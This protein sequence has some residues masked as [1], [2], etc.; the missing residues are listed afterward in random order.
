MVNINAS[1]EKTLIDPR[2]DLPEGLDSFVFY[3]QPDS[4]NSDAESI[5]EPD[6]AVVDASVTTSEIIITDAPIVS[7][8]APAPPSSIV[9]ISQ[10]VRSSPDGRQVIDVVIE[11]DDIPGVINYDVRVTAA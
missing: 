8:T 1:P 9:I 2:F 5:L 7:S 10:T 4:D 3:A 6:V 11:V